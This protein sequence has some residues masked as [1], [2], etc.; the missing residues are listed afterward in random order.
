MSHYF[1]LLQ[2]QHLTEISLNRVYVF[3]FIGQ[4]PT[5]TTFCLLDFMFKNG[6]LIFL[7]KVLFDKLSKLL[8]KLVNN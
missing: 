6:Y 5:S 4:H 2:L 8:S 7:L 1:L 3:P